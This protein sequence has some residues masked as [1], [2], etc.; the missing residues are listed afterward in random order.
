MPAPCPARHTP[1]AHHLSGRPG[2]DPFEQAHVARASWPVAPTRSAT[3]SW[4]YWA[5]GSPVWPRSSGRRPRRRPRL[6]PLVP[7]LHRPRS[8]RRSLSLSVGGHRVL[9]TAGAPISTKAAARSRWRTPCAWPSQQGPHRRAHLLVGAIHGGFAVGDVVLVADHLNLT[10]T[11]RLSA[12]PPTTAGTPFVD[13][14]EC[15]STELRDR[16]RTVRPPCARA[17]TPAR[18]PHLETPAESA[19]SPPRRRSCRMSMVLEAI[20]ARHLGADLLGLAVVANAA[21]ERAPACSRPP[22]STPPRRLQHLMSPPSC[23]ACWRTY[24]HELTIAGCRCRPRGRRRG[25]SPPPQRGMQ[26]GG[27]QQ[28]D[29][30][31]TTVGVS[32]QRR[33]RR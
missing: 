33:L 14:T 11:P 8:P 22:T 16:A 24:R 7:P 2:S 6:A 32:E 28:G 31:A 20:A 23:A 19:C 25:D 26:G 13:L 5:P 21:R 10:G 18:G 30:N 9:V 17:S 12:S 15:W 4:S 1:D 29:I 3:T 27:R